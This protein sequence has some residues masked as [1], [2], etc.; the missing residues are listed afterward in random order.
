MLL[1]RNRRFP[2]IPSAAAFAS[3]CRSRL[4]PHPRIGPAPAPLALAFLLA[5]AVL[6]AGMLAGPTPPAAAHDPDDPGQ[7]INS[8]SITSNAGPD[9]EYVTGDTITVRI[10][11]SNPHTIGAHMNVQLKIQ[12]G[13]NERTV[14]IPTAGSIQSLLGLNSMDFTYTVTAADNDQ[15]GITVATNALSGTLQH[16]HAGG[17]LHS[18]N[19]TLPNN[20]AT[21]QSNHRVNFGTDYDDDDDNL[22]EVTTLAQLDAIRYDLNGNGA[23]DAVS[24]TD[25]ARH[26]AAFDDA[27][28][29]MG[30]PN[31]CLGYELRADLDFDTDSD[32]STHTAGMG[33]MDDTYYDDGAGWTPIGGADE[34]AAQPFSG[35]L[36]GNG[37]T[38]SN[39]FI[40]RASNAAA[41]NTFVGLFA[42]LS[43]TVRNLNL[44]NPYV[45]N[46]RNASGAFTWVG[47]GALAGRANDAT[48]SG[49]AVDGGSVRGVQ[50]IAT[51]VVTNLVGCLLGYSAATVSSSW[52]SCNATATGSHNANDW[53][54]GLIGYT[55]GGAVSHSYA[56]G[57]VTADSVAG[58]LIGD[59]SGTAVT[60]SSARGAV[61]ATGFL[62]HTRVGGLAGGLAGRVTGAGTTVSYSYATGAA[63]ASSANASVGG[64]VGKIGPAALRASYATGAATAT[65]GNVKVGGLVG[66][67]LNGTDIRAAYAAGAATARGAGARNIAGGL[68]GELTGAS[69]FLTASYARGAV[70]AAGGAVNSAGGLL[71][72]TSRPTW[73]EDVTNSHWDREATGQ[74]SSSLPGEARHT[75]NARTTAELK[76]P[77]DYGAIEGTYA[78][79]Y[80]G[81]S[82]FYG[83]NIDV[84]GV[85]GND[86][87][88][89]FGTS[90]DYPILKFGHD[91]LSLAWQMDQ[92][93]GR[94]AVDYDADNDN[95]IEI[96]KLAQLDAIRYDLDG[97]GAGVALADALKYALAFPGLRLGMGCPAACAGYELAAD[98]DFDT[99]GDGATYTVTGGTA[100]V[101]ADDTGNFFNGAEGWAPIGDAATPYAAVFEG[102]RHTI[103]NLYINIPSSSSNTREHLGLFGELASG[104]AIR[105]LGLFNAYVSQTR[106][107]PLL[108]RNP[109][110][111]KQW[112]G[113]GQLRHR[114]P[115][116]HLHP[117]QYER[118]GRRAGGPQ[119]RRQ[120]NP[121]QLRPGRRDSNRLGS[122]GR[123]PGGLQPRRRDNRQLR[124]RRRYRQRLFRPG[125]RAGRHQ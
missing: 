36:E 90:D 40:K 121:G 117:R 18:T 112:H 13:R 52:A 3:A 16:W 53:A 107:Q 100:T 14:T 23:Q 49:V 87:P 10:G 67:A 71:G 44:V 95:L 47:T 63:A 76:A 105:R 113:N 48:V 70:S 110:G 33:D 86:D 20:L 7:V 27:I 29:N 39:L 38:I 120:R 28:P 106:S 26:Q 119:Q 88:W 57:T 73:T 6:L 118:H 56:T 58:G 108:R 19:T 9:Q 12:V 50:N 74:A 124:R 82:A 125:R 101:D 22:I 80:A 25:W 15:D 31:T 84:D 24:G 35:V 115:I 96:S 37:H 8:I 109:A 42:D 99:D 79:G 77:T 65:G 72:R 32:G 61:S 114:N 11:F 98:L 97:N 104:G 30:C 51:G 69:S 21:A 60:Y 81:R 17:S 78:L 92:A 83:W 102:N 34:A 64:L 116:R 89:H 62:G 93:R 1:N 41:A 68:I 122:P 75:V 91:A 43:G 45:E 55:Y 54:G 4:R 94:A 2:R 46:T 103:A 5:A 59:I 66:E 85:S 123:R 111:R